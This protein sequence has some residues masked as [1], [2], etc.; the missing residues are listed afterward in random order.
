MLV[1]WDL[2]L[3]DNKYQ[4]TAKKKTP[5]FA[6]IWISLAWTKEKRAVKKL[7]Y[8]FHFEF[9]SVPEYL[10]TSSKGNL[11]ICTYVLF[12]KSV[13]LIRYKIYLT[14]HLNW[15]SIFPNILS[16][17]VSLSYIVLEK[18]LSRGS[19]SLHY[20]VS[21]EICHTIIYN[22]HSLILRQWKKK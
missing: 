13:C 16:A 15:V 4:K 17:P 5:I 21:V 11:F 1:I 2:E 3:C 19:Y 8:L 6:N 20:R 22:P 12:C 18:A 7:L 9:L 10:L 14:V